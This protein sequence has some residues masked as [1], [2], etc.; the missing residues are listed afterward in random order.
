MIYLQ[1]IAVLATISCLF[2]TK[3][4]KVISWPVGIISEISLISIY[5]ITHVYAQI[6]LQLVFFIQS[7]IGWYNWGKPD[8][9]KIKDLKIFFLFKDLV[10][11]IILG[12]IFSFINLKLNPDINFKIGYID[13]I[14]AFI[15][16]LA[17][18]YMT[19]KIIQSWLL[20]I[21]YNIL[22]CLLFSF[23]GDYFMIFLNILLLILSINAYNLW[24]KNLKKL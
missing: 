9:E 17:N 13:G 19:K 14:S 20:Y 2:L 1:I 10:I 24:K 3:K 6:L 5:A 12:L 15:G 11:F 8:G 23:S 21:T 7:L 22:L 18:W 4:E 16:L